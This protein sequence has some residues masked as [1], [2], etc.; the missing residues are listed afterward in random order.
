MLIEE[1]LKEMDEEL[2][3]MDDIDEGS[4]PCND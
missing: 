4:R 2:K 1:E 3:E